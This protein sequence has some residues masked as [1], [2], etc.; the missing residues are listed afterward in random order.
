MYSVNEIVTVSLSI[1]DEM[2]MTDRVLSYTKLK[3]EAELTSSNS[4]PNSWPHTGNVEF[5]NVDFKYQDS[6]PNV[7]KC[8]NL[9][10]KGSSKV[11]NNEF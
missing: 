7:L 11:L 3:P 9:Y 8:I 4:P 2:I 6:T 1:G 5:R 10:I